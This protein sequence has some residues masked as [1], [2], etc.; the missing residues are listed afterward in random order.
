MKTRGFGVVAAAAALF[1][2]LLAS[3]GGEPVLKS[4][5]DK[6]NF[7]P[8]VRPQDDLF[9]SV[10]GKWLQET[11]IP[12]DRPATGAFNELRDRSEEYVRAIIEDAAKHKESADAQKINDLY[13]SFM[14]EARANKLGLA[15]IQSELD[16]VTAVKDQAGL[17][18]ELAA[19]QRAGVPGLF[20]IFVRTDS[21]R[22]DQYITYIEQGGLGLP[23]ESYYRDSKYERIRKAYVTH[24]AKMLEL[25]KVPEPRKAA[26]RI[27]EIETAV[28]KCHWDNVQTRDAD[29]TYNK[30]SRAQ[31]TSLAKGLDLDPWFD[32]VGGKDIQE[33][34]VREPSFMENVPHLACDQCPGPAVVRALRDGAFRV[35]RQNSDRHAGNPTPLEARGGHGRRSDRPRRRQALRGEALPSRSQGENEAFG[36]QPR[37]S[38]PR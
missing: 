34:V 13:T 22:S 38:L 9:R 29:K 35:Q 19:L 25:A 1:V 10:N 30:F 4:G 18:R 6:K 20:S 36:R 11:V 2:C 17:I 15:P 31:V 3:F 8:A 33:A 37:R 12:S 21:K 7:D 23:D 26:D 16:A 28:A 5:I 24:I 32:A 14:D 27:M